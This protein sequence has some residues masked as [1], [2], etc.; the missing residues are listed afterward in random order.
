MKNSIRFRP[1]CVA[2]GIAAL[3]VSTAA[4]A[5]VHRVFPGHSIQ[6]AIDA[7]VP[8]D[9]VLVEPGVYKETNN[10]KYGLRIS[11]PNLRL[12]GKVV[13][14]RGEAGKVRLIRNEAQETGIY[15][16]PAGCEYRDHATSCPDTLNGFYVRGFTV[17]DFPM[18]GIQTRWVDGFEF[19]ANESVRNRNNGIYPTVSANGL[20][21]DN[22]SYGSLDTAMWVAA[23]Q[24]VRV[25][26][27]VLFD[28]VIGFEITVS[29]NVWVTQNKIYNNTLGIG[30]FHPNGAGNP[31]LLEMA[32]WV[33]EQNDVRNNNRPND[34]PPGSFQ[35]NLPPG[36]G[37]LLSGVSD[38]V[39][40]KNTVEDNSFVG[41]GVLG[42][43]T[44]N[45]DTPNAC[46][47][48]S[49]LAEPGV[50]NNRISQNKLARNGLS[51]PPI[52]IAF[53]AADITYFTSPL[54]GENS[55]GNCFEK[56]KPSSFSYFSATEF[57]FAGPVP[58]PVHGPLPTD[59]C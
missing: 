58:L 19:V 1:Y 53:L 6:A 5:A 31:P 29:N 42:W 20:V 54:F 23:S 9:T 45:N 56:N 14:G 34:A 32:N 37:I 17:E 43:C 16:A 3:S 15:A 47:P 36:I 28:S 25:M 30:L 41:I 52:K 26:N 57:S 44:A 10:G 4:S 12:I 22:V 35:R 11:T 39:I 50:S 40:A 18:N 55:S 7:A 59:G 33:I 8:G 27:N 24:N 46:S 13:P 21:R 49:L 51:P 38:H 2:L 48:G